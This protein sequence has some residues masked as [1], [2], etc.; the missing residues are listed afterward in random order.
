MGNDVTIIGTITFTMLIIALLIPYVQ[1]E[2][3]GYGTHKDF[4]NTDVE[5]PDNII[6]IP[7]FGGL[8]N[9]VISENPYNVLTSLWSMFGLASY[10]FFP[11]WLIAIHWGVKVIFYVLIYRLVRSGGG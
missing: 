3:L 5:T 4:S 10:S 9:T 6:E 2:F 11:G 8:G 1:N 7:N